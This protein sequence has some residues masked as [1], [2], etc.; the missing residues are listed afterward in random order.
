MWSI[1]SAFISCL[2][3]AHTFTVSCVWHARRFPA[4]YL[5]GQVPAGIH[6]LLDSPVK[7][8]ND[9]DRLCIIYEIVNVTKRGIAEEIDINIR[10]GLK[11]L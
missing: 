2:K 4:Y 7:P 1:Y 8:W 10:L 5:R 11:L 6:G 9:D 3:T